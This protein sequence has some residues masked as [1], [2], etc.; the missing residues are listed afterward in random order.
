M[1]KVSSKSIST[2]V[3]ILLKRILKIQDK[4]TF[5]KYLKIQDKILSYILKIQ[6]TILKIV[7]CTTLLTERKNLDCS[8]F[9]LPI[10]SITTVFPILRKFCSRQFGSG[11]TEFTN[12]RVHDKRGLCYGGVRGENP[13]EMGGTEWGDKGKQ[14][15]TRR[16]CGGK[17]KGKRRLYSASS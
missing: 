12:L 13:E 10:L 1:G 7:S 17:G 11:N 3:K 4:D 2:C 9:Y 14:R 5:K 16:T 6:D 15:S 8:A